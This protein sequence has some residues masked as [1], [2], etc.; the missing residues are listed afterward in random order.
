METVLLVVTLEL[1]AEGTPPTPA[2][3]SYKKQ[4]G[5]AVRQQTQ[6]GRPRAAQAA[7][8]ATQRPWQ[9]LAAGWVNTA[10]ATLHA[11]GKP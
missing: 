10:S 2:V 9:R 11:R 8:G 6:R 4:R 5:A 3:R 7:P 1:G